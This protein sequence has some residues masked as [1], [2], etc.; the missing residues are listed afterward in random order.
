MDRQLACYCG[1]YFRTDQLGAH[2]ARCPHR[3]QGSLVATTLEDLRAQADP[4]QMEVL[5]GELQ[6]E[7]A[8]LAGEIE[9]LRQG[10]VYR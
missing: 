9:T 4:A 1:Q 2:M 10:Q 8:Q 5:K 6:V 3:S 7:I